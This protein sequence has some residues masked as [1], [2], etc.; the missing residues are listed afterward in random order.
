MTPAMYPPDHDLVLGLGIEDTCVYPPDQARPPLDEHD[1]TDHNRNW[2]ADLRLAA[3][4]GAT[5]LRYGASWPLA[6]PAPGRFD[7]GQLDRVIERSEELGLQLIIDLVHYGTPTW[8]AGAFADPGYPAAIEEFAAALLTRYRGRLHGLTPLNEPLTTA[9]FCGL[10]GVWPPYLTGWEGWTR[11]VVPMATGIARTTAVARE[12]APTVTVVH[13]E[14]STLVTAAAAELE[15]HA[16]LLTRLGWL[17][18]DLA[19]GRV[20]P[21]HPMHPWLLRQG[22]RPSNLDWLVEHAAEPDVIGVNYY[23]N[24]TPRQVV[25]GPDGPTQLAHNRWD[26]GLA[27]ALR[28]FAGRYR[29]PLAITETSIEGEDDLRR[30]WLLDSLRTCGRLRAEGMDLRGYT[31]WPL[32]DFID[33]S[34]ASGGANVEEFAVATVGTDGTAV[35]A[36]AEPLGVP[37]Q[38]RTPFLRRMGLVQLNETGDGALQRAPIGAARLFADAARALAES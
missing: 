30:R 19:L 5:T 18:T 1:L 13:V 27:D 29:L 38:G 35:I 15:D 11:V 20:T 23:P 33:W 31:W 6:H 8:L 4:L 3:E 26:E 7:W 25:A 21:Q 2:A 10:R 16:R 24:L 28:G 9:S 22:A 34:W 37:E 36:A 32:F 17:P 14:A 12:L